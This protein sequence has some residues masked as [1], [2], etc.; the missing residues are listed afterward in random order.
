M[1]LEY[2]LTRVTDAGTEQEMDHEVTC[3]VEVDYSPGRKGTRDH[4][5]DPVGPDDP[6]ECDIRSVTPVSWESE[7]GSFGPANTKMQRRLLA[8]IIKELQIDLTLT[9]KE[10]EAIELLADEQYADEC[11]E[12]REE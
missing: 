9:T 4:V 7:A 3:E 1:T 6:A 2:T 11:D 5:F 12:P 10:E 8:S